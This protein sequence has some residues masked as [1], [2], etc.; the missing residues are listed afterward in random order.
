MI[1]PPGNAEPQLGVCDLCCPHV[2]PTVECGEDYR[3]G[4]GRRKRPRRERQS[5]DWR[6]PPAAPPK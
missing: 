1:A 6:V 5:P 2:P 3:H 4:F